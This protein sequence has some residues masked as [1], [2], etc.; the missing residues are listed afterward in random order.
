LRAPVAGERR[1]VLPLIDRGYSGAGT[2]V[3][4]GTQRIF[5]E[6]AL[7]K[8]YNGA[9]SAAGASMAAAFGGQFSGKP[10][11]EPFLFGIERPARRV[12]LAN[13]LAVG[14]LQIGSLVTRTSDDGDS[15]TIADA[16]ADPSEIVVA[17]RGKTKKPLYSME[18]GADAMQSCS[19]LVFDKPRKQ[20][21]LNCR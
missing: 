5:V 1:T 8:R 9:T 21:I 18:I 12:V 19:S 13:P 10:W 6:F 20:I 16:D 15:S 3:M 17:G 7:Y 14:P 2:A 11:R 4:V